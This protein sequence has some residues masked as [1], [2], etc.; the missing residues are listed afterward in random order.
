VNR[1]EVK[2]VA[3][4]PVTG[5]AARA[6]G[7]PVA[8]EATEYTAAGLLKAVRKLAEVPRGGEH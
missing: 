5:D 2:L 1:G 6:C 8:A 4:S 3:I 7:Y